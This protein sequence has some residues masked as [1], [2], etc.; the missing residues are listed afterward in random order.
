MFLLD[1]NSVSETR[2]RPE[3][4]APAFHLWMSSRD[5]RDLYLSVATVYELEIGVLAKER[6]DPTQGL[7]LRRWVDYLVRDEFASRILLID[8][9]VAMRS[10]VLQVPNRRNVVDAMVAATAYVH[11]MTVVTRNVRDFEGTG[12]PVLNPWG[13]TT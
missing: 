9:R 12:V 13:R 4:V 3:V 8:T 6:T 11:G 7:R 1:T 10:A 5:R 2:K